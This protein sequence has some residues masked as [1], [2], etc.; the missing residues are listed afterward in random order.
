MKIRLIALLALAATLAAPAAA[1]G[2][3]APSVSGYLFF[4]YSRGQSESVFSQGRVGGLGAGLLFWGDLS[5]KFSYA[6]E[7]RFDSENRVRLEQAWVA[8]VPSQ[9]LRFVL[10]DFLVPFGKY[11]EHGRPQETLLVHFP[12]VLEYAY[13]ESWRELGLQASG[14]IGFLNVAAYIGN[15]LAEAES[16]ALGQQFGD[17]NANKAWGGRVGFQPSET[18]DI[19]VSYYQGKY[20]DSD[21]RYLRILGADGTWTTRD[22]QVLGEYIKARDDNPAPFARGVVEGFFVQLAIKYSDLYLVGSFQKVRADDPFHGPGWA[23]PDL[24]GE[25]L[26]V[27]ESRWTAGLVY[28]PLAALRLKAEYDFNREEGPALKNNLFS[29]QAAL[30]F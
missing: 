26:S 7:A 8:F 22:F 20:D 3:P 4:D 1:Q 14:R 25:G 24:P 30:S 13:P 17:N 10:G 21:S 16:L 19:G 2:I 27:R 6:L 23:A 12:L 28:F 5:Q 15:G 29:L 11:N 9:S 18:A